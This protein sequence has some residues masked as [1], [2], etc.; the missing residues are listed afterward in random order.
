MKRNSTRHY[1]EFTKD[2][3]ALRE[4]ATKLQQKGGATEPHIERHIQKKIDNHDIKEPETIKEEKTTTAPQNKHII[5][6]YSKET[7]T[8]KKQLELEHD[9]VEQALGQIYAVPGA[10]IDYDEINKMARNNIRDS[11]ELAR[12]SLQN[13][14]YT[15]EVNEVEMIMA[16]Y[17]HEPKPDIKQIFEL[18]EKYNMNVVANAY[19][20]VVKESTTMDLLRLEK[21]RDIC[22]FDTPSYERVFDKIRAYDHS[23]DI[24]LDRLDMEFGIER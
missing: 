15:S 14:G 3:K 9:M 19:A 5:Q 1:K 22:R 13:D 24:A 7:N 4:D 17:I 10:N 18:N 21:I 16:K 23:A 20:N 12:E 2:D 6:H 8:R 11:S